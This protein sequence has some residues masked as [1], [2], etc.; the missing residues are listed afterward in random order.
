[1]QKSLVVYLP[2]RCLYPNENRIVIMAMF[3]KIVKLVKNGVLMIIHIYAKVSPSLKPIKA[4]PLWEHYF[5]RCYCLFNGIRIF[6][7]K[8]I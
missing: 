1:M 2:I 7:N 8:H 4:I 3:Y 6:N 5:G